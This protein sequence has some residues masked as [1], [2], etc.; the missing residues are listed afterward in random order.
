MD[1]Y[2]AL[3]GWTVERV[4]GTNVC[5]PQGVTTRPVPATWSPAAQ[6]IGV[7]S[8]YTLSVVGAL[9]V[10]V[11]LTWLLLVRAPS[12]PIA[13]PYLAVMEGLTIASGLALIGFCTAVASVCDLERRVFGLLTVVT[14]ALAAGLTMAVHFAQL[15][16]VRQLWRDGLLGDYRLVWPSPLFAVEYL[17]WDLLVG[18]TMVS[19]AAALGGHPGRRRARSVLAAG[20]LCCLAGLAGPAS[21]RMLL[22]NIAVFGYAILLPVGAYF[23]A[24]V[25]K[26][27]RAPASSM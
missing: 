1:P 19:G 27:E 10:G 7:A 26:A 14:G 6:R 20:G 23:T 13:D 24:R 21:G 12:D 11:I 15:T 22:Q 17:A 5:F 25:F 3:S 4:T 9:Y 8:G 16:A 18:L 2:V